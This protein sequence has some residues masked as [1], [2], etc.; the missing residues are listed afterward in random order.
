MFD[1]L[2]KK[3]II[4]HK[5]VWLNQEEYHELKY[6]TK[7]MGFFCM[8]CNTSPMVCKICGIPKCKCGEG[9]PIKRFKEAML[10]SF[11]RYPFGATKEELGLSNT[12][13]DYY[14]K[15]GFIENINRRLNYGTDNKKK[16]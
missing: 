1:W 14:K 5:H 13:I 16:N 2:K 3:N 11:K 12:E 9:W 7:N 10:T 4:S 15:E 8:A 6:H